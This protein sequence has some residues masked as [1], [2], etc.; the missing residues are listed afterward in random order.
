MALKEVQTALD[1]VQTLEH[2]VGYI[3]MTS[4]GMQFNFKIFLTH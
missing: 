4:S 3:C 1:R 2:V